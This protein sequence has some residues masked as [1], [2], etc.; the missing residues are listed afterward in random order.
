MIKSE[1]LIYHIDQAPFEVVVSWDDQILHHRP[2]VLIAH[3]FRGQTDFEVAKSVDLAKLGYIAFAVDLYGQG[4]RA[5]TPEEANALMAELNNNRLLLR[6]RMTKTLHEFRKHPR[7]DHAKIGAIGF[8]F[9]GKCVLDL[10][11]SGA[12]V[13]GVVSFH[14]IY[15]APQIE[16]S[17]DFSASVL[18]LHGWDDP[19][20]SPQ[21]V[22]TLAEEL[23]HRNT[24][25]QIIAFGH[26]GHAFTNPNVHNRDTGMFFQETS[27]CRAWLAMEGFLKEVFL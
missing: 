7:V 20:A 17:A 2:G 22:N 18:V 16:Y 13:N 8:C 26:T 12:E 5:S 27:N 9:G 25:W 23:T 15:D 6:E 11:R 19:L 1:K 4:R 14:G 3:T 10:A 24:D 21:A